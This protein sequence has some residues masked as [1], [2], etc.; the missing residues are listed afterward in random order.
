MI[1]ETRGE[2]KARKE[3]NAGQSSEGGSEE[4]AGNDHEH[5]RRRRAHAH[6]RAMETSIFDEGAVLVEDFVS[7]GE[8]RAIVDAICAEP[9]LNDLRRRV[10]HYG[11][12]YD[13]RNGGAQER[14]PALRP[15]MRDIGARLQAHFA[16][17]PVQCIVN[18][19]RPGQGIGMHSDHR[20]FGPVVASLSLGDTWTM[21]M[22]RANAGP[23]AR[24]ARPGD[25][26]VTL[27]E[28]SMLVLAGRARTHWM[29]GIDARANAG[30]TRTRVSA[31]F[32]TLAASGG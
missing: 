7:E 9:W 18:E 1:G 20:A 13:Y 3:R 26:V 17:P 32:R 12:R 25:E 30:R 22:R 24:D 31:T 14:A 21:Q 4:R 5:A 29:H 23:Y 8:A 10:Q 19:Y 2:E 11:Y 28:R 15:W 16:S 6:E 27:A